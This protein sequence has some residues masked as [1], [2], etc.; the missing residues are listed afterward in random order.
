MKMDNKMDNKMVANTLTHLNQLAIEAI[1]KKNYKSAIDFFTQSL[2]LEEKLGMKA[3]MAESFYNMAGAYYLLGEYD[4]AL[5]KTQYAEEMFLQA[6]KPDD[7]AKAREMV[8]EIR[9]NT[10]KTTEHDSGD[11]GANT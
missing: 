11:R 2:V 1:R 5:Q 3:Q 8:C 9:E 7:A 6:G 10:G 4:L